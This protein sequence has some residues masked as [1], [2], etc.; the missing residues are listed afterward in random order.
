LLL[1]QSDFDRGGGTNRW[2]LPLSR[3]KQLPIWQPNKGGPPLS[4]TKAIKI[5]DKWITSKGSRGDVE[6]ILLR[7]VTRNDADPYRF[8]FYYMIEFGVAPYGNHLTCIVLMDG[9]VLEPE[10][11]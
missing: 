3:C 10:R 9:T 5:A 11:L 8:T 1:H 6:S 7:P 2:W 4:L